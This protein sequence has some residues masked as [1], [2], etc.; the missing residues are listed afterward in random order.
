VAPLE[1]KTVRNIALTLLLVSGCG[2]SV[3]APGIDPDVDFGSRDAGL[4]DA[5]APDA[6]APDAQEVTP[7]RDA[8]I[9][10]SDASHP[11]TDAGSVT[12]PP[13]DDHGNWVDEASP[14][15]LGHS[16]R[17]V[18]NY[19]GDED[20]FSFTTTTE[21][22]YSAY[23]TGRI[24]T[25]C[26]MHSSAGRP[27]F[28][29]DD[30]GEGHNCKIAERL[31]ANTVYMVSVRHFDPEA[32][33]NY[34]FH[35]DGP[36]GGGPDVS[37]C[38]NSNVE[39]GE[40]CDDGNRRNGDGCSDTCRWEEGDAEMPEGCTEVPARQRTTAY[41]WQPRNH[42]DAVAH[43]ATQEMTLATVDDGDDNRILLE[44]SNRTSPWIGLSDQIEED[45]WVWDGRNSRFRDWNRGEPN[46]WGGGEDCVQMTTSGRWNDA[47]CGS[48]LMFFC[49][50]PDG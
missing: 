15:Q 35:V 50:N 3:V 31:E 37:V 33:G 29:D 19:G 13:P 45:V 5:R 4:S 47:S 9:T 41:C 26:V 32:R 28:E 25:F 2:V 49:E 6:R 7:T 46:D 23:T 21:G 43:C 20:F 16:L 1:E 39:A 12:P 42:A 24:D 22:L 30:S 8:G 36:L 10:P 14:V 40:E 48:L 34:T 11:V 27:L 44:A 38:G 18:V 17:G